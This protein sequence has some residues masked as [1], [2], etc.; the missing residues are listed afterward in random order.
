MPQS[1]FNRIQALR[2]QLSGSDAKIADYIL[3]N[4]NTVQ[5]LT[6]KGLASAVDVSTATISRFVKRIGYGSFREFSL[7]LT[8]AP[9]SD[10]NFFGEIESDDDTRAIV[11]K[12]FKGGENALS[13]TFDL[14]P[15]ESWDTAYQWI[16]N[17]RKLGFF[18]IGGSSI[19]ALDGYHKFLRTP[20]D[21]EQHPDYD[22]QLM[23]AVRMQP[24]DVAIVISHSG[25]NLDTLK[26]TRQLKQNHVK[27]IAITAHVNSSLAKLADLV[28]PSS[29]AEVNLRS[30]SM[31]SLLAQLTIID[32]LFTLVGVNLGSDTLDVVDHVRHAIDQTRE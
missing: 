25:R 8:A 11:S 27:I 4:P 2:D 24:D 31:S 20:I 13:S 22:V 21:A 16:I 18:G 10:N 9:A 15:T 7:S 30:E 28:L 26:I 6:I 12:V 29:A 3:D 17:C 23:Q 32:S 5:G 14:I 19:V 1:G